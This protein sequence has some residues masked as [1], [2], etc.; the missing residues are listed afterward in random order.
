[1]LHFL[2]PV[3][4]NTVPDSTAGKLDLENIG[5]AVVF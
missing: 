4:S 5:V 2:I 3:P 1:M